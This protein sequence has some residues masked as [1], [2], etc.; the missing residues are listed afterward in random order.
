MQCNMHVIVCLC[1]TTVIDGYRRREVA[2]LIDCPYLCGMSVDIVELIL[3]LEIKES[4][5]QMLG[6]FSI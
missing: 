5:N 2:L 4:V 6:A 1:S 3:C